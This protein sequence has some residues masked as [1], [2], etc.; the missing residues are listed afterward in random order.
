MRSVLSWLLCLAAS[1]VASAVLALGCVLTLGLCRHALASRVG[2]VW[3]RA[4]LFFC[5]IDLVV[6][7]AERLDGRRPRLLVINHTS[8]LDMP[9]V[10]ALGA[11]R[12]CPVAKAELRWIVPINLAFWAAGTVFLQRGDRDKAVAS[13][14]AVAEKVRR[15]ELTVLIS[16]EGTRSADGRLQPFKRGP[17]HL[18]KAAQ[19][20]IVPVVVHGA[21]A[22]M[23]KGSWSLRPGTIRL[24]VQPPVPPPED[25]RAAAEALHADYAAWLEDAG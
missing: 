16:P 22:L 15:Q 3:G 13:L 25:P 8:T 19:A 2:P 12:I 4:C 20:E 7:G 14:N 1:G 18:A 11:P 24:E 17:F 10:A 9:L 5:G 6:T 21:A 23:P